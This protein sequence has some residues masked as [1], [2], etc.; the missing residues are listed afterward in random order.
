M[1]KFGLY[2][3]DM[4]RQFVTSVRNA[5]AGSHGIALVGNSDNGR[6]ALKDIIRLSPD[7]VLADIPL[8]EL[9]GIALLRETQRL[10]RPP[11]VII[12]TRFCS[13]ATLQCAC[14][15]GAAFFLCKPIELKALPG[16]IVEC[17]LSVRN[18]P[19]GS[20][21]PNNEG[22]AMNMRAEIARR[23]LKELGMPARLDGSAYI[24][25]AVLHCH[26]DDKLLR[27]LSSGLYAELANRLETTA[28]RIERSLRSAIAIA[29]ER[30]A[31]RQRFPQ[32]PSNKAFLE[33]FMGSVENAERNRD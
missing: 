28:P 24:L 5:V 25:E 31:L 18:T 3:A 29:Y 20:T 32:K 4:D 33:Y 22:E 23:M 27:N 2:I 7:V 10:R 8:P 13:D 14:K 12:C 1:N 21:A 11:A 26:G 30:G 6:N 16:L 9:D 17:A 19:T 15:Y